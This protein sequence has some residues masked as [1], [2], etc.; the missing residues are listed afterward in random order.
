LS[1]CRYIT[2]DG[3][4]HHLLLPKAYL[5]YNSAFTSGSLISRAIQPPIPPSPRVLYR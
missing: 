5:I 2:F 1:P 4:E 3:S